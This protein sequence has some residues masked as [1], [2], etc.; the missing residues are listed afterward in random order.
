MPDAKLLL[1]S[2]L[3]QQ[4][5][6]QLATASGEQPWICTVYYVV[7]DDFNLYWASWPTRRHSLEI[8]Q[9]AR[10]AA[11][12]PLAFENGRSVAGVQLQGVA[13]IVIKSETIP[14]I[15]ER[16]AAKFGRD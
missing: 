7:D 15:A 13:K 14:P 12:I 9:N 11:A 6:M 10:V 3:Q 8:A 16:Y 5:M 1:K 4:H 2:Y